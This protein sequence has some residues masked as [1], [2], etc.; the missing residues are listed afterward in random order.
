MKFAASLAFA[1]AALLTTAAQ[2]QTINVKIGVLTDMSSL[3]AD[4]TG[5]G[6][7]AAAKLAVQ[8]F[9]PAAHNMKVDV[10]SADH[11]NKPDVGANI[12]RQWFDVD[13]VDMMLV[14]INDL[15]AELGIPGQYDDPRV[16]AAY[17]R[18]IAACHRHGKH[19]GIGGLASRPDL[20]EKFVRLGARFVSTG[21]DLSFLVA[22]AAAKAKAVHALTR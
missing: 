3:Y 21:T 22:A 15:T 16:A 11:Q 10:V 8:D 18:T 19:V 4:A 13:G 12:A 20:V 17:E 5:P 1:A 9:D 14:G 2:A 7:L 6:S